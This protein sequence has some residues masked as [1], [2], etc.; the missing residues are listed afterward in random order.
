MSKE[1]SKVFGRGLFAGNFLIPADRGIRSE[2]LR[3]LE[4]HIHS[5]DAYLPGRED[6]RKVLNA[7]IKAL[8]AFGRAME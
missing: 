5:G 8:E 1:K 4:G 3:K 7:Q 2:I 6:E